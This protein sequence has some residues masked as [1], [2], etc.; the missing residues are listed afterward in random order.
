MD[1]DAYVQSLLAIL[2]NP[3]PTG[4][5]PDDPYRQADDGIDRH[6]GFG[7]EVWI[8]SIRTSHGEHGP[9]L[10]IE[11]GL[12]VPLWARRRVPRRGSVRL[13]FEQNWR[14]LS[15]FDDP[16]DYATEVARQVQV[17]AYSHVDRH[18]QGR[19]WS[20]ARDRV[21][22]G[23]PDR[24]AQW[25]MLLDGLN[26]GGTAVEASPGRIDVQLGDGEDGDAGSR[27]VITVVV[28]PDQ[29]E[30][31]LVDHVHGDVNLYL[32]ELLGPRDNDERFV[33]FYQGDL[34]R[35]SREELP[36]VR[37]RA[38]EREIAEMRKLHPSAEFDW[39]ANPP[40]DT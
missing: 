18:R 9:E 15:G 27:D 22:A 38:V 11:F 16:A 40:D 31:V 1:N 21:R 5:D 7:R 13:P 36:P 3:H 34:V 33:V 12:K 30:D 28:T 24:G 6:D 19:D 4:I 17:A 2:T 29:W 39:L 23:L 10:E 25:R 37:G 35:S 26:E 32:L 20:A 14:H 8:E